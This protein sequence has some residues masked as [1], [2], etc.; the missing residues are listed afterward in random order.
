MGPNGQPQLQQYHFHELGFLHPMEACDVILPMHAALMSSW[1]STS[2]QGGTSF[3]KNSGPDVRQLTSSSAFCRLELSTTKKDQSDEVIEWY[4]EFAQLAEPYSIPIVPFEL[5]EPEYEA[6]GI[7][8]PGIGTE[9]YDKVGR[10]LHLLLSTKI[11]P[12]N[13]YADDS[14]VSHA[15]SSVTSQV[16]PNGY[17][18]LHVLLKKMIP[19]FNGEILDMYWP[20]YVDYTTIFKYAKSMERTVILASKQG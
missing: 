18:L 20:R 3:R 8:I 5:L 16:K 17:E 7:C 10:A 9:K 2:Y 14:E 4:N 11:L 13:K 19:A 12:M 1:E 6:T 15:L